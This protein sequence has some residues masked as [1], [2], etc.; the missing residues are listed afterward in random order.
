[1]GPEHALSRHAENLHDT[2]R[3]G[4]AGFGSRPDPGEPLLREAVLEDRPGRGAGEDTEGAL[5]AE[6]E[7]LVP[8][9]QSGSLFGERQGLLVVDTQHLQSAEA[10]IAASLLGGHDPQT[11][12]V[13]LVSQG[14]LPAP[15]AKVVKAEGDTVSVKKMRERDALSWVRE[16]ARERRVRVAELREDRLR[17]QE[18][19]E[20]QEAQLDALRTRARATRAADEAQARDAGFV[21]G[22][23]DEQIE[24]E[25]LRRRGRPAGEGAA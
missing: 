3:S 14:A 17:L 23:A 4:V 19:L 2:D 20:A 12:V 9:L 11:A 6:V 13:V 10:E 25:L 1:M 7:R 16:A 21:G 22:V 5:R 8:A 24:L 18:R 15:V